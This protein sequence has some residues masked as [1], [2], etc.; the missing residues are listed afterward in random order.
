MQPIRTIEPIRVALSKMGVECE[1]EH[2]TMRDL[3]NCDTCCEFSRL[4]FSN[5]KA[6]SVLLRDN[7]SQEQGQVRPH[8]Q[9]LGNR[10]GGGD[11][12]Q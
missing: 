5:K 4:I 12:A 11:G 2:K 10:V 8:F 6:I 1:G 3:F 7:K 9:L